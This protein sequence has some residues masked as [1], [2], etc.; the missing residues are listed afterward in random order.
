VLEERRERNREKPS[1][2]A[3]DLLFGQQQYVR[4]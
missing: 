1:G 4:R 3:W 2:A